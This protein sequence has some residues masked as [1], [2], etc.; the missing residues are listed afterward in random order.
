MPPVCVKVWAPMACFT[1]PDS[2]G[3]GERA[4]YPVPTPAAVRGA[5][6]AILW[7]PVFSYRIREI[8]VLKPIRF[9]SLMRTH[10][11]GPAAGADTNTVRETD[12]GVSEYEKQIQKARTSSQTL[13]LYDVAYL[14]LADVVMNPEKASGPDANPIRYRDML[15][16]RVRNGR[17][18]RHPYLGSREFPC[19][20]GEPEGTETP[21]DESREL[22]LMLFDVAF[23]KTD[24][25]GKPVTPNV[26]LYFNAVMERGV[27]RV[28]D[29]LYDSREQ[30]Q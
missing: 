30:L 22:G 12:T 17:Y 9:V 4:S 27:I 7:K 15:R 14:F 26:P 6:E 29:H 20:F 24:E 8:H 19:D 3:G 5:L 21:I 11:T 1:R 16:Q 18:Y 13:A 28:P 10:T 2:N 23:G 25:Q